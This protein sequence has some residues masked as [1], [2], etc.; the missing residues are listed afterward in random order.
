MDLNRLAIKDRRNNLSFE[1]RANVSLLASPP[2][3]LDLIHDPSICVTAANAQQRAAAR[4]GNVDGPCPDL[5]GG[6]AC[7]SD[8]DRPMTI[9]IPD[10]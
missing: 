7:A 9:Q 5:V 1:D 4:H 6:A 8:G 3:R 10:T 2:E